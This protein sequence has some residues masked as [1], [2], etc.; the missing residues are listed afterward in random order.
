MLKKTISLLLLLFITQTALAGIDLHHTSDNPDSGTFQSVDIVIHY[1]DAHELDYN[2]CNLDNGQADTS[3]DNPGPHSIHH[4]CHGH[5][6][7][8]TFTDILFAN[9][10]FSHFYTRFA[11]TL[12]A[13]SI[14]LKSP[15]RPPIA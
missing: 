9:V 4:E 13:Y 7:S 8:F 5:T 12:S 2:K 11:Y 10:F 14:T 6:T 15:K 3:P 1:I